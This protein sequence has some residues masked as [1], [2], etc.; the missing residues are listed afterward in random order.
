MPTMLAHTC[1]YVLPSRDMRLVPAS[2][3]ISL[4]LL[5]VLLAVA[6]VV[7]APAYADD[8]CAGPD[9]YVLL[10]DP[11]GVAS[12]ALC[13]EQESV[14]R[15]L[16]EDQWGEDYTPEQRARI[17]TWSQDQALGAL[18]LDLLRIVQLPAAD[19]TA[20][21][22]AIYLWFQQAIAGLRTRLAN[23]AYAEQIRYQQDP[24]HYTPPGPDAAP[25]A[26]CDTSSM[27]LLFGGP[28]SPTY[29]D[30]VNFGAKQVLGIEMPGID[31][32]RAAATQRAAQTQAI[33]TYAGV[34]GAAVLSGVTLTI[35]AAGA[36]N[37]I[38]GVVL[39]GTA[40][41]TTAIA[42]GPS[43]IA[44]LVG[45]S[46]IAVT[47][48]VI[49]VVV[50]VT[51]G[52]ALVQEGEIPGK[53]RDNITDA[54]ALIDI[55][56]WLSET[57]GNN[58]IALT[59]LAGRVTD[60][61]LPSAPVPTTPA[62][63][64]P[65]FLITGGGQNV[66]FSQTLTIQSPLMPGVPLTA[67]L[68]HGWWVLKDSDDNV[69]MTHELQFIDA[70][71]N[72]RTAVATDGG[73]L[74]YPADGSVTDDCLTAGTCEVGD[75]LTFMAPGTDSIEEVARTATLADAAL[76]FTLL[77]TVAS[78]YE[79]DDTLDVQA[80]AAASYP[81]TMSY[82]WTLVRHGDGADLTDVE[83]AA[84]MYRTL[85]M[86][87]T[88][89]LTI[90]ATASSGEKATHSWDF[91][92][93]GTPQG[94]VAQ[95]ILVTQYPDDSPDGT[96]P[97][98][99]GPWLEGSTHGTLCVSTGSTDPTDYTVAFFGEPDVVATSVTD[100]YVCVPRP[101]SATAAGVHPLEVV[102]ACPTGEVA[103][104][105]PLVIDLANA[106]TTSAFS[107]EVTNLPGTITNPTVSINGATPII[108]G[109]STYAYGA[110]GDTVTLAATVTDPGASAQDVTITW[111]DG[112]TQTL[113]GVASGTTIS[114]D[115][116]F[117]RRAFGPV[118]AHIIATDS[119]GVTSNLATAWFV[120]RPQP[121]G[122]SLNA[123]VDATGRVTLLA[124][125][126][127]PESSTSNLII[128]WGD[129]TNTT[130]AAPFAPL[131]GNTVFPLADLVLGADH[132]YADATDHTITVTAYN[133]AATDAVATVTA[134]LPPSA[135]AVASA[136]PITFDADGTAH[137]NATVGDVTPGQPLSLVVDYGDG[138]NEQF[139]ALN[140]G[141]VIPLS[142]TYA[143][144]QYSLTLQAADAG[145]LSSP[146]DSSCLVIGPVSGLCGSLPAD[147]GNG[148]SGSGDGSG[149][150]GSLANTGADITTE[151]SLAALLLALGG[152]LVWWPAARRRNTTFTSTRDS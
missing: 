142:H 70:D 78:T 152:A 36:S 55:G 30:F 60:A 94:Q 102:K 93:T 33:A 51:R 80:T 125:L 139:D 87:G 95:G 52:V 113:T 109:P 43:A 89:T 120:M 50:A 67:W 133:G 63:D 4:L 62:V 122:I 64:S 81:T 1:V 20:D 150:G 103:C 10:T 34:G 112:A 130:L 35:L 116:T 24:C 91:T 100:G 68:D 104:L 97:S 92:V 143:P 3:L 108:T 119:L 25:W 134:S 129:G 138:T 146:L 79:V 56:P 14:L 90:T 71:G 131:P 128:D 21:E 85:R 23:A 37:T 144:G 26:Q 126:T 105:P 61:P 5:P 140:A 135:P 86:P 18:Y 11:T 115:H 99:P 17:L 47:A 151:L 22:A 32:L 66:Q 123:E 88:Y 84:R 73:I 106:I 121:V 45:A 6:I 28:T 16:S 42:A 136:D 149:S 101:A 48:V 74:Q 145:G 76:D 98:Q 82:Q 147:A 111:S 72:T 96:M 29:E 148:G 132:L 39:A 141:D 65:T 117:T 46:A 83:P 58:V 137:L 59:A 118:G 31:T 114:V 8:A 110:T 38:A 49:L 7:A 9:P 13:R 19:R 127:D 107:Y 12:D 41:S 124:G 69:V 75:S 2:R 77:P 44:A 53:L 15:A 57:D 40:V 54:S 27:L